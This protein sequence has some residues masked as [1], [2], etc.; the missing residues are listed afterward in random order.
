MKVNIVAIPMLL[1]V[2]SDAPHP[3]MERIAEEIQER[4][5][6]GYA[7]MQRAEPGVWPEVHIFLDEQ[8]PN[9]RGQVAEGE[10]EFPFSIQD[11]RLSPI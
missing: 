11:K 5:R 4:A 9:H 8:V 3:G 7:D 6:E 2:H 10:E 1:V